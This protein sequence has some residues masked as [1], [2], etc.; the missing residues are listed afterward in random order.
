M[1]DLNI[2]AATEIV[3]RLR[4]IRNED[5]WE[6]A[7]EDITKEAVEAAIGV[8]I[9][10]RATGSSVNDPWFFAADEER[11]DGWLVITAKRLLPT[12]DW[13]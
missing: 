5:D 12:K 10:M 1:S 9:P 7:I 4:Y 11:S 3:G 13:A 8:T 2:D 6:D